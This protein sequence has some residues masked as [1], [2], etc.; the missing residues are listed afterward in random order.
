M[1]DQKKY[2]FKMLVVKINEK[3][4]RKEDYD[5]V[6]IKD[7]DDISFLHLVSAG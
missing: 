6:I 3:P 5:S 1:L 4:V 2:T 7:G